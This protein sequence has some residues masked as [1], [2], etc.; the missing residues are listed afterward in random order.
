MSKEYKKKDRND[1]VVWS[2]I[3]NFKIFKHFVPMYILRIV[4]T[5]VYRNI[6]NFTC[7]IKMVVEIR[8][9]IVHKQIGGLKLSLIQTKLSLQLISLK[10]YSILH[11]DANTSTVINKH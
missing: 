8:V 7:S 10:S 3:G 6:H 2:N 4:D 5:S 11:K 1:T 9:D